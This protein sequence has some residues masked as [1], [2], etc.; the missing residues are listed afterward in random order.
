M[1]YKYVT[2]RDLSTCGIASDVWEMLAERRLIWRNTID[3]ANSAYEESRQEH[4]DTKGERQGSRPKPSYNY[5]YSSGKLFR[6]LG[7][8][9]YKALALRVTFARIFIDR[10]LDDGPVVEDIIAIGITI[11]EIA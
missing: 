9:S 10:V 1:L 11:F 8:R 6:A 5:A 2:K 7:D 3:R 4:F